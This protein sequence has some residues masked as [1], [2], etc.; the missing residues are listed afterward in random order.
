MPGSTRS[1]DPSD[2]LTTAL[3]S[4]SG[5][6]SGG[7]RKIEDLAASIGARDHRVFFGKFDPEAPPRTFP[8]RI[9]RMLPF[10]KGVL[11][12]GDFRNW[13]DIEA[14]A[15]EIAAEAESPTVPV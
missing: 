11:P 10:A 5:P 9:V 14:W 8:E 7:R 1:K 4:E 2:P 12:H 15:L 6:G 3:G 13:S